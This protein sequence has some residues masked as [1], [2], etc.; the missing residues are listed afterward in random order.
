MKIDNTLEARS[1][2]YT[3]LNRLD[4]EKKLICIYCGARLEPV[5]L[6]K[7]RSN[8]PDHVYVYVRCSRC[9]RENYLRDI[10]KKGEAE[11]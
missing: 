10:V 1:K 7:W 9:G 5:P 8:D 2:L 3:L 11:W 4:L 6:L